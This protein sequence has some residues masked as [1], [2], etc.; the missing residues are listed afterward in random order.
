MSS[1]SLIAPLSGNIRAYV[2][3]FDLHAVSQYADGRVAVIDNPAGATD[4]RVSARMARAW[5]E[6]DSAAGSPRKLFSICFPTD[7]FRV[8]WLDKSDI[9]H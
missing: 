6:F 9:S 2:R 1:P 5:R 3:A 7:D 8:L 4:H